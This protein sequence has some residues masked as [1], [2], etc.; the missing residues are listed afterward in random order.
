MKNKK[1]IVLMMALIFIMTGCNSGTNSDGEELAATVDGVGIPQRTFDV[2]YGIRRDDVVNQL[3]EEGLN[4]PM[5]RLNRTYGELLR[6]NIL[7]S[8]ISNQVILNAAQEEDLGDVDTKVDEQINMEKQMSGDEGF[9]NNLDYLGVT[10]E[11]YRNL[12]KDNVIVSEY[13]T[14]KMAS[15][16][17]TDEEIQNFY[18]ENQ[19]GMLQAQARH[20]LVE[21]EEEANNVLERLEN[22]EDFAE[23]ATELSQDPGSAANGGDLGYFPRGRMVPEFEEFVFNSEVG[24][25]SEPIETVH[26]FHIIEVTDIKDSVEDFSEEIKSA[27]QSEKFLAELQEKEAN[28]DIK[29]IYDVTKEPKSI[30]EK[31]DNQEQTQEQAPAEQT[32]APAEPETTEETPA[33]QTETTEEE[34]PAEE[35]EGNGN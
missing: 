2:Y 25:I 17:V 22:G 24:E 20:I 7:D 34:A 32:E 12:V 19:E 29:K 30:Q 3:G 16:E 21:T 9:Q 6:E 4:Q 8:L 26:G 27:V 5:D 35:G 11:E 33:E 15:Y 14:K 13:R 28:A 1:I 31:I 10:E 18:N 23:L